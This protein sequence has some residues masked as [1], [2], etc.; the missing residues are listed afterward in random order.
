MD[1]VPHEK[2]SELNAT[3]NTVNLQR[4]LR[5]TKQTLLE[6]EGLFGL[7]LRLEDLNNP[8]AIANTLKLRE[9]KEKQKIQ[10]LETATME[11]KEEILKALQEDSL[12]KND[13]RDE[14]LTKIFSGLLFED[15]INNYLGVRKGKVMP[16]LTII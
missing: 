8:I 10:Q 1:I 13:N 2:E 11:E 7:V 9:I 16:N 12:V 5:K 4:D 6:L 3:Q 15:K 14:L